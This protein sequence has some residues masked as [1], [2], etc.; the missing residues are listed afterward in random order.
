MMDVQV[1][2]VVRVPLGGR[3]V[4]GW[5]TAVRSEARAGLKEIIGVSGVHPVFTVQLLQTLRWAAVHY[6]SPLAALIPRAAPPNL[7]TRGVVD[8]A[9][10]PDA[11]A[12]PKSVAD[13][14][15]LL[16]TGGRPLP[17]FVAGSGPWLDVI[18]ALARAASASGRSSLIVVPTAV[19]CAALGGAMRRSFGNRVVSTTSAA[20]AAARTA[21][22]S[23][24]KGSPGTIVVGT[25]EVALWS[26]ASP[27][28]A[29]IVEAGRRA[30]KSRQTPTVHVRE[31]L[32][33]RAGVEKFGLVMLGQAPTLETAA[34]AVSMTLP[35]GRVWP[36]VEVIDRNAEPPSSSPLAEATRAAIAGAVQRREPVYVFVSRRGYAPAARCTSCGELR[37]CP[38]CGSNPGQGAA[39]DRC[40][41]ANTGCATCGGQA[42]RPVGSGAGR[43]LESLEASFGD[44]V[45]P[46]GEDGLIQVGTERDI[47]PPASVGLA[48][49]V[50]SDSM[51]LRPHYRAE[52]DTLRILA[53]VA[54][55]VRR[56]RGH[57]CVIQSRMADHRV[58]QAMRHGT[59]SDVIAIWLAERDAEQLPPYGELVALE[60]GDAV[61]DADATLRELAG[62]EVA[63][64]G[65]GDLG[66][67]TRWLIQAPD[68]RPFKIRLRAQVQRWRDKGMKVRVDADPLD[69]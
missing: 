69:V 7:A 59:A 33:R 15:A 66:D 46:A 12:V 40:G 28:V 60:L 48:V 63:V 21:A 14:A 62:S 44:L 32:R 19:E 45:K 17:A 3:R 50:D 6:V 68:L 47:P 56:G 42:F 9:H 54:S 39:C 8:L 67:S 16:E 11:C 27:G 55:T 37:R 61:P 23:Q 22:W 51:L 4:R 64:F 49:V 52:E 2:S 43:V 41:V 36:L 25:P 35:A 10:L 34:A 29:V 20:P 53:R 65:P 18:A 31:L 26:I 5:V 1:G 38:E 58:L 24:A 57:R 30:M 13:S